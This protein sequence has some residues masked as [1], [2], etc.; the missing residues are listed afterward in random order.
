MLY[1]IIAQ[2]AVFIF[3]YLFDGRPGMS[4]LSSL[5]YFNRYDIF[6]GQI[7]RVI[8]F[9]FVPSQSNPIFMFFFMALYYM[10]GR[11]LEREWGGFYFNAFYF[12]G[13]IFSIIGGFI[14]GYTTIEYINLSLFL[15]FAILY[16]NFQLMVFLVIPVKIK[17]LAILDLVFLGISF[18]FGGFGEKI[19]ILISLFNIA[20]FFFDDYFPK[21]QNKWRFRHTRSK[22]RNR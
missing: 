12:L 15:A 13:V 4:S 18:L 14:I 5:L 3:D 10:I 6:A 1:I 7:W 17:Y 11:S 16:P 8:T 19:A 20:I 22:W 2:A 9:V 21:I